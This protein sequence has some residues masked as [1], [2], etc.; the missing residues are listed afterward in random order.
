MEVIMRS[1][2]GATAISIALISSAASAA[3]L[4]YD[5]VPA[6]ANASSAYNWQGFYL[7]ANLGY[8]WGKVTN[9]PTQ[10]SGFAGGLGAGY[11]WQNGQIVYGVETD[12]QLTGADDASPPWKFTNPWFGTLRGRGGFTFNNVL[13]YGTLGLAFGGL[14]AESTAGGSESKTLGGWTAGLG[15]EV[16]LTPSWSAKAEY[17]YVD[18]AGRGYALTGASNGLE[19]NLLRFGANYR[20]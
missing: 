16:G 12:I 8:Q 13:I 2:V 10:P 18:F 4:G 11:N 9:N 14:R 1:V 5:Q 7:G 17:L 19:S 6:R 3:D 20:F 15:L